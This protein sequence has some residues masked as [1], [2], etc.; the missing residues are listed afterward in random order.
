[1]NRQDPL[2]S[3]LRHRADMSDCLEL[4]KSG[5]HSFYAASLLLPAVYRQPIVA[6]YAFCR[7]ADDAVDLARDPG[8][9]LNELYRRLNRI[10]SGEPEDHPVDRAFSDVVLSYNIPY[11]LPSALLDGFRWDVEGRSYRTL[12]DT[13]AYAARVAGSVGAMMAILM[14]VRNADHLSRACDLGVA[15]QLTNICRDVG[16]DASLGRLYLPEDRLRAQGID[17]DGWRADPQINDGIRH[18]VRELLGV[19]DE[20]YRRSEWGIRALPPRVRPAIFAART[21][22]AEIGRE[23]E[24]LGYDSVSQRAYVR[25]RRK[26]QLLALAMRNS[27]AGRRRDSAPPLAETRFLVDAVTA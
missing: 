21:I 22:Y 3:F 18:V 14:G 1:M 27:L 2:K 8:A 26:A 25:G 17:V 15:M 4:L 23:I 20:L 5:S 24:R 16:E 9:G 19:A 11:T 10:Y 7:V 12:S 13:Q 6:L